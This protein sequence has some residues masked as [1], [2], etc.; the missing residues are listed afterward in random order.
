MT[1]RDRIPNPSR[2]EFVR[3]AA[4][5]LG[6]VGAAAQGGAHEK[7]VITLS[8][9]GQS[10]LLPRGSQYEA[11][12]VQAHAAAALDGINAG[13]A[14]VH[15]RGAS[16]NV[17]QGRGVSVLNEPDLEN[18]RRLTEA[19]RSKSKVIVN[20]GASAMT[21]PV[22]KTLLALKPEA[23]SFLVGHH[24]G[25]MVVPADAQKQYGID[26]LA[27]GVLP[28]VEV[29][30]TGDVANFLAFVETGLLRPP[31]CVTVFLNYTR[32]YGV[33]ATPVQLEAMVAMLPPNTHWTVC[34][35]GP[36]HLDMAAVAI[37]RGGHVRTGLENDVELAPGRPART[38][39]ECVQRIVQL[40]R[41]LGREIASPDDAR[42]LLALPRAPEVVKS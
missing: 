19:V 39:G 36:K 28:E 8:P 7:L 29:F 3:A 34:V 32:Y 9:S 37:A 17:A 6:G 1:R 27:A 31:Y 18:W 2:R 15:L 24:Y 16:R 11:G 10:T 5:G 12:D 22:R 42:Q 25:G 35:R 14:I 13:A 20:Y 21:P 4:V 41:S 26:Y 33:P 23:G 30:H 38:Q 40:A